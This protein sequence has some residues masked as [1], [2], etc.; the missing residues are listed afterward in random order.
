MVAESSVLDT[1]IESTSAMTRSGADEPVATA[2]WTA[3]VSRRSVLAFSRMSLTIARNASKVALTSLSN[4]AA[5]ARRSSWALV[6]LSRKN[7]SATT[8]VSVNTARS[9]SSIIRARA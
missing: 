2:A 8:A 3:S 6:S 7:V 4:V 1:A 9:S 5:S